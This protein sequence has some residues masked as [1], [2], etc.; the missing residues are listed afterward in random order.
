MMSENSKLAGFSIED[1][2]RLRWA[3]RDIK[4]KRTKMSPVCPDDL[5]TLIEMGFFEMRDDIPV[6]TNEGERA[7]D[8]S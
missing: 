5:K 1:A 8:W 7:L 6:L 3:L 4:A 2:I